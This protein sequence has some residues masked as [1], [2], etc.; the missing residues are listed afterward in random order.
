MIVKQFSSMAGC[1]QSDMTA[2]NVDTEFLK[3]GQN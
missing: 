3:F 1:V 2:Q